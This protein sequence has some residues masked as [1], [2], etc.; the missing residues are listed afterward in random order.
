MVSTQ[1][2]F[3]RY[4]IKYLLTNEQKAAFMSGMADHMKPDD[5][6]R[7]VIRNIYYDTPDRRLARRSIEKP[8]Y[9][10]K[11]RVRSYKRPGRDDT[12]F[13]ELKKKYDS[14]VYKRRMGL[15]LNLTEAWLAGDILCPDRSQVAREIEYFRSIYPSLSPA[16]YISYEREAFYA[17]DDHEFRVTF[18][19]NILARTDELTLMSDPYGEALLDSGMSLMEIKVGASMP[20]WCVNLLSREKIYP[21]SFSKYGK[22]YKTIMTPVK[23]ERKESQCST[24]SSEAF[25]VTAKPAFQ[26][27]IS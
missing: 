15:P 19:E 7:S 4:E 3:K 9:K 11:L 10:E 27:R 6:G 8:V 5:F 24:I 20:M 1:M 18:D 12:V 26:C 2:T 25:L 23:T 13:I 17:A 14:C 21:H 16:A 22:T